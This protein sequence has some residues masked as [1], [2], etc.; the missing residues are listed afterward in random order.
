MGNSNFIHEIIIYGYD[1][2][3]LTH[4]YVEHKPH[5]ALFSMTTKYIF[6]DDIKFKCYNLILNI[7]DTGSYI[8]IGYNNN[9]I[10]YISKIDDRNH[11]YPSSKIKQTSSGW[12]FNI[13]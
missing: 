6:N 4:D 13:T 2:I 5:G 8:S 11:I 12:M 7:I 3:V 9:E 10:H 1:D